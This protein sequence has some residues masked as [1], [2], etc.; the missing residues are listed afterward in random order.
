M[1]EMNVESCRAGETLISAAIVNQQDKSVDSSTSVSTGGLPSIPDYVKSD[2][3]QGAA[4][5]L[6][7]FQQPLFGP[8]QALAAALLPLQAAAAPDTADLFA[9]Y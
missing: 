5:P 6:F 7:P 4:A 2:H 1:L 8:S 9:C 3:S